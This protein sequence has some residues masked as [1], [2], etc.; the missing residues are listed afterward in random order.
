MLAERFRPAV[1]GLLFVAGCPSPIAA[2]T[3]TVD[4]DC[5]SG[6]YCG[7]ART[8][9]FDCL[10]RED[11]E[12]SHGPTATCNGRGRCTGEPLDAGTTDA[13]AIDAPAE[14]D[15]GTDAAIDAGGDA[16][17]TIAPPRP[18]SPLSSARVTSRSPTLRWELA[19]GT[20]GA[21]IELCSDR[22]CTTVLETLDVSGTSGAPTADLPPGAVFWRLFGASG[23]TVGTVASPTWEIFVRRR[24]ASIDTSFGT[25]LDV[26][27]DGRPDLAVG[28][29]GAA[30]NRGAVY[31]H[32]GRMGAP[33]MTPSA[34]LMGPEPAG[35]FGIVVA[36]A[37]DV[38]GDGFSDLVV[39]APAVTSGGRAYV[40]YGS[41]LGVASTPDATLESP[42]VGSF[43][44]VVASIGDVNADGYGDLAI[45]EPTFGNERVYVF[46]GGPAGPEETPSTT[47]IAPATGG[48]G[49]GSGMGLSGGD[50]D[51]D[52]DGDLVVGAHT[53]ETNAGQLYV[54][55]GGAAG[56]PTAP[57]QTIPSPGA[58]GT[59][60]AFAVSASG[61]VNGDGCADLV[62]GGNGVA[63]GDGTAYVFAG[64]VTGLSMIA[65]TT[66]PAPDTGGLGQFGRA[67]ASAGDVDGDGYDDV[68]ISAYAIGMGRTFVF[69]GG[70]SGLATSAGVARDGLDPGGATDGLMSVAGVGDVD[71][72]G[73]DDVAVGAASAVTQTGRLHVYAGGTAP[74]LG[75]SPIRSL[76]G[77]AANGFFG[78]GLAS[79]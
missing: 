14:T 28:A 16:G 3:C 38:N 78:L 41:A 21:R 45:S 12:A 66:I 6:N 39:G 60:F 15:S 74:L 62:T 49:F 2:P 34:T 32:H 55:A 25:T 27:G 76:S 58:S 10:E 59:Y 71:G 46:L 17:P 68:V 35:R 22:A 11:C 1:L 56:L 23:A 75:T 18:I 43:G 7:T 42:R 51:C 69:R 72:D 4:L 13:P 30:T 79:L 64:S 36:S 63:G 67:V 44:Q 26:N 40:Y 19:P 31:V 29:H 47:L 9:V 54:Y 24:S 33:L 5:P 53:F 8:C 77:P 70:S 52:G 73:H 50:V 57:T 48:G 65:T 61:D 37:G 20:D